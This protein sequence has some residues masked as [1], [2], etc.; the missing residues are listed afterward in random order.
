MNAKEQNAE[1][2]NAGE[3]FEPLEPQWNAVH[4][5]IRTIVT[6]ARSR[7]RQAVNMEMVAAYWEIGRVIAEE[8]LRGAARADYG[9]QVVTALSGRLSQEFGKGF[10]RSNLWNMRAL[11]SPFPILGALRRELRG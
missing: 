1:E 5:R 2:Q 6:Q 4:A 9:K 7:S 10:D 11:H 8:E 3:Q